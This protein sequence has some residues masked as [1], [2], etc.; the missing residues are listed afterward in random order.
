MQIIN[1]NQGY[2]FEVNFNFQRNNKFVC[3][4]GGLIETLKQYDQNGLNS[5]KLYDGKSFKRVAKSKILDLFSWE[6]EQYEYLK[7]HYFFKK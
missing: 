6:T 1:M 4:K 5:I 7:N 2:V 3:C